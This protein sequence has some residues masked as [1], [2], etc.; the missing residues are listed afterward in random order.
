MQSAV[1]EESHCQRLCDV[2]HEV[3]TTQSSSYSPEDIVQL[4]EDKVP[5]FVE[6][7]LK[8]LH[9]RRVNKEQMKA[10]VEELYKSCANKYLYNKEQNA[11]YEIQDAPVSLHLTSSDQILINLRDQLPSH[12]EHCRGHIL[13]M[14]RVRLQTRNVFEWA[15]PSMV[16]QRMTKEV[17]R[18]FQSLEETEFFM[19]VI[20]AMVHH[21]EDALY[22]DGQN[23]SMIHLWFGERVEDL[24]ECMQ[25][26]LYN[27]TKTLSP[28]WNKIK[29][30]MHRSYS[31]P[32]ICFVH[33][34]PITH[35]NPFRIIKHSP[36]LFLATCSHL[37]I[38]DRTFMHTSTHIR[39]TQHITTSQQLFTH[40]LQEHMVLTTSEHSTSKQ[41][42]V[43]VHEILNDFAEYLTQHALPP[44]V[45]TKQ[46]LLHF[47]QTLVHNETYGTRG[48]K[49]LY[50][51][52]FRI[53][54][55]ET[56]HELFLR[57]CQSLLQVQELEP[58]GPFALPSTDANTTDPPQEEVAEAVQV[59]AM[60]LH[61][62][63]RMWCK[64]YVAMN[65]T[66]DS[67][68]YPPFNSSSRHWYCSY[69]LFS[70][71]L[72]KK[73]GSP[74]QGY[75][76][77]VRPPADIW[78]IYIDQHKHDNIKDSL[79]V[80]VL[81]EFGIH[82]YQFCNTNDQNTPIA[83]EHDDIEELNKQMDSYVS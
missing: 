58:T 59:T 24:I 68:I 16:V 28:F 11:F 7:L 80:W 4:F 38:H 64:H 30:R 44:D 8:D 22:T 19:K 9:T 47:V 14:V 82:L 50:Y 1:Q 69:K 29:R 25:R 35:K 23:K 67:D 18:N 42:F 56:L 52:T 65:E 6:R 75:A 54:T 31:F 13:K 62:N 70:V 27:A 55:G 10:C 53:S 40:Y 66:G 26:L 78:K 48:T 73:F 51:A 72:H 15:P 46:E 61:N 39:R 32:N 79:E 74:T 45:L 81:R 36:I 83:L 2:V 43:L 34:P 57:F 76:I 21:N 60:Q 17:H 20:G 49:R 3:Y 12:L 33:F 5:A 71:L 41:Q 77:V 63:Y 37:F